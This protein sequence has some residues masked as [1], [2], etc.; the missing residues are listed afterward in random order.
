M[1]TEAP[2]L[3]IATQSRC[4][5]PVNIR[6][7]RYRPILGLVLVFGMPVSV[8]LFATVICVVAF[9]FDMMHLGFGLAMALVILAPISLTCVYPLTLFVR[10]VVLSEEALD[11][12]P[13]RYFKIEALHSISLL[14]DPYEDYADDDLPIVVCRLGIMSHRRQRCNLIISD[15][16]AE[17]II[18]WAN[19]F[20]IR[21]DD[22]RTNAIAKRVPDA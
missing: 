13:G 2:K 20:K 4:L 14:P 21:L 6:N 22:Q 8:M 19:Q 17:R 10:R 7:V 3:E 16:D 15:G 18:V 1:N 5:Y 11:C 12:V 9:G